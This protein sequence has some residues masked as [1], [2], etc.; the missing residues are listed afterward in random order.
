MSD[1]NEELTFRLTREEVHALV[2][3]M[4]DAAISCRILGF[5]ESTEA[6]LADAA[7]CSAVALERMVQK[8]E[9]ARAA[10][11]KPKEEST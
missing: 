3:L 7:R 11:T 2:L 1:P 5:K 4:K 6:V 8:L 10:Q 9:A